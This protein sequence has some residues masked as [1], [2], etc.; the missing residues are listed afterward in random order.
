[1]KREGKN[2]TNSWLLAQVLGSRSPSLHSG[3]S[4]KHAAIIGISSF[5]PAQRN[6]A[7]AQQH[8]Q[9]DTTAQLGKV[10]GNVANTNPY[11]PIAA[12]IASADVAEEVTVVK[13]GIIFTSPQVAGD[14][15][16]AAAEANAGTAA[17]T[18]NE[19]SPASAYSD[20]ATTACFA[21]D[22]TAPTK[23]TP[24]DIHAPAENTTREETHN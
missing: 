6:T 13:I 4:W 24:A 19:A 20:D 23:P 10:V 12:D 22:V 1:M 21:T 9:E 5:P 14:A 16:V 8:R 17:G 11:A 15:N 18:I 2:G 7:Q 3:I